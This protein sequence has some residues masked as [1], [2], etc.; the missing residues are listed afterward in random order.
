[1]QQ[2]RLCENGSSLVHSSFGWRAC[3]HFAIRLARTPNAGVFELFESITAPS[4]SRCR[5]RLISSLPSTISGVSRQFHSLFLRI[6]RSTI[7]FP[8]QRP[9]GVFYAIPCSRHS[10]GGITAVSVVY[11]SAGRARNPGRSSA[12]KRRVCVQRAVSIF[13]LTQT[14]DISVL[15][16]PGPPLTGGTFFSTHFRRLRECDFSA[17]W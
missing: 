6:R 16:G 11:Y 5:S 15:Y 7:G 12:A 10:R 9:R 13:F 4:D 8:T 14:A 3:L 17:K 1:M 2:H